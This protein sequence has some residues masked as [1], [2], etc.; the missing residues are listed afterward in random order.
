MFISVVIPLFNKEDHILRAID[1]VLS[2][3]YTNFELIVVDDGSTDGS[4]E[5]VRSVS[6]SRLRFFSQTNGGVS[7]AR[8]AG[9]NLASA[10]WVAFLDADDE[11]EPEFLKQVVEFLHEHESDDLSMVGTDCHTGMRTKKMLNPC[12][13]SGIHDYFQLFQ[14]QRS[15]NN[16]SATVVNK[17]KFLEVGG[18]PE[19]VKQFEDWITWV[20]LAFAGC[21]GFINAPLGVYHCV[22]GSASQ[23]KRPALDFFK[24]A[25]Q[26]LL[27]IKTCIAEGEGSPEK[28]KTA[29]GCANEFAVNIAGMIARNG[30][31]IFALKLLSHVQLRHLSYARSGQIRFLLIHLLCPQWI[32][33]IYWNLK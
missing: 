22:E 21:F 29:W 9:V 12:V 17:Q 30:H 3:S 15:P 14:N 6:D 20:K 4:A 28:C 8:N 24:D 31:K 32:K 2:Q 11:Y 26:F 27:T 16:S 33:R 5:V 23:S 1:S 13:E 25:Q 18:F 7:V 19:G 10:D